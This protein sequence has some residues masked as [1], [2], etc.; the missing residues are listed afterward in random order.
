M[1]TINIKKPEKKRESGNNRNRMRQ[2]ERVRVQFENKL[3]K[4]IYKE[5][6]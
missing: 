1:I 2:L 5:F 6:G 4:M 3:M